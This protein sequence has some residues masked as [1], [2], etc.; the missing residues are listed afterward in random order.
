MGKDII[1][2][3]YFDVIELVCFECLCFVTFMMKNDDLPNV[4]TLKKKQKQLY[5]G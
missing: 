3:F 1:S 4:L 5:Q 2:V